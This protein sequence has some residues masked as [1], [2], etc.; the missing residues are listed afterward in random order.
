MSAILFLRR[1]RHATIVTTFILMHICLGTCCI[2]VGIL[3]ITYPQCPLLPSTTQIDALDGLFEDAEMLELSA[4]EQREHRKDLQ[5]SQEQNKALDDIF[6][7]TAKQEPIQSGTCECTPGAQDT[8]TP[9]LPFIL[10]C[11]MKYRMH[12]VNFS[13]RLELMVCSRRLHSY[14]PCHLPL[15]P[16][17]ILLLLLPTTTV[18][19][20]K[21]LIL[22][23]PNLPS[24]LSN[25]LLLT[26]CENTLKGLA[27][28]LQTDSTLHPDHYNFLSQACQGLERVL[29]LIGYVILQS[30]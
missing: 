26:E 3:L 1:R 15:F 4:Q 5:Y 18:T 2:I 27:L 10:S 11:L 9:S 28:L 29:L 25:D 8:L 21:T 20:H 19:T 13:R 17:V 24:L 7:P 30:G 23:C 6:L 16:L 14:K 12:M 22:V